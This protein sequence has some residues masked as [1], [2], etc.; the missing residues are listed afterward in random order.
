MLLSV[1]AHFKNFVLTETELRNRCNG[2][3]E[4]VDERLNQCFFRI[5]DRLDDS[6]TADEIRGSPPN[7]PDLIADHTVELLR[8]IHVHHLLLRLE[9]R[10]QRVHTILLI[11]FFGALLCLLAAFPFAQLRPYAAIAAFVILFF[12][13]IAILCARRGQATLTNLEHE[14]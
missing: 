2:H 7:Q 12:Q 14:T 1:V 8:V 9:H 3:R 10:S 11:S 5:F 4:K 13:I 6:L